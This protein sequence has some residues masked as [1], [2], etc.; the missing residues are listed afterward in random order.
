[1]RRIH[2]MD[3]LF[4]DFL[5]PDQVLNSPEELLAY[6]KDWAKGFKANA[7]LVLLPKS[8]EQVQQIVKC[9]YENKIALVPS[10][11]RTGLSA[12]ATA[13]NGEVVLS[14]EKLNKLISVEPTQRT[15]TCQA[16]VITQKIQETAKENGLY[17]P[18]DLASAGSSQIGGNVATNAGGLHV[19]RYGN[20][21]HWILGMKAVTGTG[22]LLELN[23]ELVKNQ[24]G[25]DLR[26]LLIG[27]EGTL[28]IIVELTL[29]L[30]YRPK[31][32]HRALCASDSMEN[33]LS[34]MGSVR[35][36]FERVSAFEFFT[37]DCIECVL[38]H[39]PMRNPFETIHPYYALIEIEDLSES[40]EEQFQETL[41]GIFEEE[42]ITD[43][44]V[45]QTSLQSEE[46]MLLRE[47]IGE[48]TS[49]HYTVH[50][51]DLAVPVRHI[52]DFIREVE[53][54][55]PLLFPDCPVLLFGHVGDGNL[56][57]NI[58]KSDALEVEDF[59]ELCHKNDH[60]M[61]TIIQQFSGSISAEHGVGLL[62]RDYLQYCRSEAE[63]TLMRGIKK[64][65]DPAGIL[66]PGKIFAPE[67]A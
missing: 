22:E 64:V 8:Y 18:I 43:V 4:L 62:K 2:Y 19:I 53:E 57:V 15:L 9:C 50:K 63:I 21:R 59:F 17:F 60:D 32:F 25:Y 13:T 12:G 39:H 49:S 1:M 28:G 10:G 30:A 56:H 14:L 29:K 45:A 35:E 65:F 41:L 27:S 24:T 48:T 6:G 26:N 58:L 37:K 7:S 23:G 54:R 47:R 16:G 20:T 3:K 52:A 44:V 36:K 46:L 42:R 31:S 34:V 66:N 61:F 38:K 67:R 51:N 5:Q 11:G 55:A 40:E 33:V